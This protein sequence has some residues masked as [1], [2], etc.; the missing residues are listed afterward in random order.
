MNFDSNWKKWAVISLSSLG[1]L[2]V[3]VLVWSGNF[4]FAQIKNQPV[5][6]LS[7]V[8]KTPVQNKES[9]QLPSTALSNEVSQITQEQTTLPEVP[10]SKTLSGST[11]VF[12]T[13]NNCGP[14]SLSM[15]LSFFG[16]SR[17]QSELGN[18]LR[19]YQN[20]QGN[21]D[22][23]S[24]T[25][26]ELAAKAE[27][28]DLVVYHRPAGSVEILQQLIAQDLPVIARTWLNPGEDIGHYRVV[29]GYDKQAG[30]LIQDDSLQ[31]K[32]LI[33]SEADFLEIWEPFNFELLVLVSEPKR[34]IVE[35]ILA[36]ILDENKAWSK[37]LELS[38]E[39][40]E[41]SR[42]NLDTY[43]LFNKSVA[44]Y[45]LGDYEQSVAFF[46]EVRD[47]LPG[48]MLW[49]QIEPILAYYQLGN[50]QQV[51]S[52]SQEIFDSQNQSF[53]ELLYLRGLIYEKQGQA[54]LAASSFAAANRFN[55]SN[56]WHK[57]LK[58]IHESN[59]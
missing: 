50:Y 12:Q 47:Q 23:K 35:L 43:A 14:A 13:F 9:Q 52:I 3:A 24:V 27:E 42:A 21:N 41:R 1:V 51:M 29:K 5:E 49:Y 57:N 55:S 28:F 44:L 53:S 8:E 16:I 15:A 25:L 20:P 40:I 38:E 6:S 33:Y 17:S 19:P 56:Y 48:R 11:H 36:D 22:D 18:S 10:N 39:K 45:H 46:E 34:E 58:G 59:R 30:T 31:G 54:D 2:L 4:D 7:E 37:A 32:N 26:E